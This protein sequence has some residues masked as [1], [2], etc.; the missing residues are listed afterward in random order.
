MK[1]SFAIIMIH[2]LPV[3]LIGQPIQIHPDNSHYFLFKKK[4]AVLISSAE[5][6]GAVLNLDFDYDTYLDV[7][8][9]HGFNQTRVFS[10]VYCEN[11]ED[12]FLSN[13]V[14]AWEKVQNT[15]SPRPGKLIAPWARSSEHGYHNGGNKFDLDHW[16][17]N[18]FQRLKDFCQKA[19]KKEIVVEI[20][21]F[22]AFYK[23]DFWLNS[24]L[25]PANNINGTENIVYNEFHL[26]Q[27]KQLIDRQLKMVT[28]IVEE[29]N[30]FENIYFEICNEPYWLP[31]IP[32]VESSIKEQ[33][34][35][36]EIE[37]WQELIVTQIVETEKK[38]PKRHMIAQNIANTYHKLKDVNP[39]VSV[40]NFHYAFPPAVVT[41][42][43]HH[44]RPISFDETLEGQNARNRRQEAWA[45][46]LSGG[47]VYSNLDWSFAIDDARGLGRNVNGKR[48][49][50]KEVREQ[51]HVLKETFGKFD[52][53]NARPIAED[54]CRLVPETIRMHGLKIPHK[55]YLCYFYKIKPGKAGKLSLPL[56][57]GDYTITFIHPL[58]GKIISKKR[59]SHARDR[60][61]LE[62]PEFSDDITLQIVRNR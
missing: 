32:E 37:K 29:L 20:V 7:L 9:E 22:T 59:F 4:P 42:N 50:G 18:Y 43:Y 55:S 61:E 21:L 34:F 52:F 36:P 27:N 3:I 24:P 15:L 28:R 2:L 33:Q 6:Y 5:H 40:L 53:I 14:I 46:M 60:L 30:H 57:K 1:F 23:P 35:L 11:N 49:S 25:N 26:L 39:E 41:D 12:M 13:N 45:F 58:D 56:E 19:G 16:D 38:L 48:I 62:M 51:L 47:A 31:G 17:E 44:Q 54:E 10:G 8:A